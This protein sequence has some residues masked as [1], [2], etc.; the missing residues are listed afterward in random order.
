MLVLV[1]GVA[2][3]A[4]VR[5]VV[6]AGAT[7]AVVAV[8]VAPVGVVDEVDVEPPLLLVSSTMP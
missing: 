2:A 1:G 6:G 4:L 5:G 7:G 3:G 8:V